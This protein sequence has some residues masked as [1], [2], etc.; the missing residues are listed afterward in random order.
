MQG[1]ASPIDTDQAPSEQTIRGALHDVL[2]TTDFA[3][4]THKDCMSA[5]IQNM[6]YTKES[7]NSMG[8]SLSRVIKVEL[9]RIAGVRR[10]RAPCAS[11]LLMLSGC[12][13]QC[14]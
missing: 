7:L 4:V 5:V 10:S 9:E 8:V 2:Q 11:A 3:V 12:A 6:G 13:V 14:I 1:S